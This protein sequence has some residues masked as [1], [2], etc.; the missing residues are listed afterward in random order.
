MMAEPFQPRLHC[1]SVDLCY[2]LGPLS[3]TLLMIGKP[4]G[5]NVFA[6]TFLKTFIRLALLKFVP[7]V[8]LCV[9]TSRLHAPALTLSLQLSRRCA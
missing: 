6:Q 1:F 3:S 7:F 5:T 2:T 8:P 4:N 9:S